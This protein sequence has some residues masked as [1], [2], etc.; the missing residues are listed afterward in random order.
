MKELTELEKMQRAKMYIDKL[1]QG[2]NPLD[3]TT[4]PEDEVINNVRLSRCLFYVSDILRQVIDNGGQTVR[5]NSIKKEFFTLT[6]E[7]KDLLIP[8]KNSVTIKDMT[9]KI[10]SLIDQNTTKKFKATSIADWLVSID[11]LEILKDTSGRNIKPAKCWVFS[12]TR[13]WVSTDLMLLSAIPRRLSNLSMTTLML[14]FSSTIPQLTQRKTKTCP[15]QQFRMKC[16][17]TFQQT[18]LP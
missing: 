15:G 18:V 2:I 7:Q 17:K 4:I 10:N 8:E 16:L 3:D 9:D 13:E 12:A 14:L 11:L 6:D 5:K 1:A